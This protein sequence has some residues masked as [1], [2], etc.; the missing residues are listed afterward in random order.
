MSG[1]VSVTR[2]VPAKCSR[3]CWV[4]TVIMLVGLAV[5]AW[6]AFQ[7]PLLPD[8]D[9]CRARGQAADCWRER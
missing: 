2:L 7:D 1:E 6:W 5:L 8:E 9:D 3:P 4:Q